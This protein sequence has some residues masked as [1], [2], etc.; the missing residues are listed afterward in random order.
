MSLMT[1]S[2][3]NSDFG[4]PIIPDDEFEW[5]ANRAYVTFGFYIPK[6]IKVLDIKSQGVR[7]LSYFN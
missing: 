4:N 7:V 1:G 3:E 5:T 2:D 6:C